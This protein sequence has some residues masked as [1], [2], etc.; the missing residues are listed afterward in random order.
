MQ[1]T[2]E[3]ALHSNMNEFLMRLEVALGNLPNNPKPECK[4]FYLAYYDREK[5]TVE[6]IGD[7]PAEKE[8]KYLKFAVKKVMQTLEFKKIRSKEFADD[9]LGQ[10]P[11][12]IA[13]TNGCAGVSGHES[14]VDE[15]I[16]ALWLIYINSVWSI[17]K[18]NHWEVF[19]ETARII[20]ATT[21]SD[22]KWISIIAEL[23]EVQS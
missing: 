4:G 18:E 7:V 6:K 15:A 8:F 10:Y 22:N 16:S 13:L 9:A 2:F 5:L 19:L 20:E 17:Q 3:S 21:A 1:I 23:I 14:M 12:A 11:G